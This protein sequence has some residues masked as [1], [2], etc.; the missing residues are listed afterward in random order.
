MKVYKVTVVT[1]NVTGDR[2]ESFETECHIFKNKK[3]AKKFSYKIAKEYDEDVEENKS[4]HYSKKTSECM[5]WCEYW[6]SVSEENLYLN[7][8]NEPMFSSKIAD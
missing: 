8:E 1:E 6:I 7:Q 4:G 2:L 3:A 5:R